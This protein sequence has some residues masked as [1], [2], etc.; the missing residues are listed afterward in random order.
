MWFVFV[1]PFVV[2][3]VIFLSIAKKLFKGHR[4]DEDSMNKMLEEQS[5]EEPP[6]G[7]IVELYIPAQLAQEKEEYKTCEYCGE[8]VPAEKR[9]CPSCGAR[10]NIKIK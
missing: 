5:Y 7:D 8:R 6:K 4:S 9:E 3:F 1:I 2:F 10:L